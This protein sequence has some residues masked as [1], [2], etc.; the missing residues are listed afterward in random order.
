MFRKKQEPHYTLAGLPKNAKLTPSKK[1]SGGLSPL[2]HDKGVKA[3]AV[4]IPVDPDGRKRSLTGSLLTFTT[5]ILLAILAVAVAISVAAVLVSAVADGVTAGLSDLADTIS[6]GS[7]ELVLVASV[8]ALLVVVGTVVKIARSVPR[9]RSRAGRGQE[10]P[11]I[12]PAVVR[13][14]HQHTSWTYVT[15]VSQS[16]AP[17]QHPL[18]AAAPAAWFIDP[19]NAAQFRYWNGA[20]WT[21]HVS[22]REAATSTP[23][24]WYPDPWNAAKLRY[25]SGTSWTHHLA[26]RPDAHVAVR[27][28]TASSDPPKATTGDDVRLTMSSSEWQAHVRAWMAAGA[29][30]QELWRRLSSAR[31]SDGDQLT[32]YAQRRMEQL[33][34]EQGT[35]RIK[36]MLEANP[37]LREELGLN[38]FLT[39]FLANLGSLEGESASRT[40]PA[41]R[42]L[43]P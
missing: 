11:N 16:A 19:R 8:A 20:T 26:P 14:D 7:R 21:E 37:G 23:A 5:K 18:I 13:H 34:A 32:L 10:V 9:R 35:Q 15:Q 28:T 17:H 30:E 4:L 40:F 6:A 2:V 1:I 12:G 27:P 33:T 39:H 41:G 42:R 36:L 3:Q 25:W 31:I 22:P 38:E 43:R 29:V 24:G